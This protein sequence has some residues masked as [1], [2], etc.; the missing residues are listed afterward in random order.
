MSHKEGLRAVVPREPWASLQPRGTKGRADC[1][2]LVR[3]HWCPRARSRQG[4]GHLLPPNPDVSQVS[5]HRALCPNTELWEKP[6][7][8]A[9]KPFLRLR[10]FWVLVDYIV[11]QPKCQNILCLGVCKLTPKKILGLYSAVLSLH[12]TQ[13][14]ALHSPSTTAY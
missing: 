12:L 14:Q 7:K 8:W 6:K 13:S 5:L 2:W 1:L 9:K 4:H 10:L 3:S 11:M